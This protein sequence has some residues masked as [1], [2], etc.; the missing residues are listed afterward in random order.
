MGSAQKVIPGSIPEREF[1]DVL[2]PC[3]LLDHDP[4]MNSNLPRGWAPDTG[5]SGGPKSLGG[6]RVQIL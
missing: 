1:E 2:L 3:Y 4:L 6:C 5:Q